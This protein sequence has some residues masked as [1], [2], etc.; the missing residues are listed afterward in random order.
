MPLIAD[1]P[2]GPLRVRKAQA[3]TLMTF[4]P[5]LWGGSKPGVVATLRAAK[6]L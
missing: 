4:T 3:Q 1:S 2:G 5:V 6:A